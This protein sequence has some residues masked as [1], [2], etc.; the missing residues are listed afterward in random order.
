MSIRVFRAHSRRVLL[1]LVS[2]LFLSSAPLHFFLLAAGMFRYCL[3]VEFLIS[4]S[5][6]LRR[7][8]RLATKVVAPPIELS[9]LSSEAEQ[10][11]VEI[12][13]HVT[14]AAASS[15]ARF[16]PYPP[17]SVLFYT[18]AL[19]FLAPATA[20]SHRFCGTCQLFRDHTPKP[21]AHRGVDSGGAGFDLD[22]VCLAG[23]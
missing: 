22:W 15:T 2:L 23:H 10:N 21:R 4:T 14:A 11:D 13:S 9:S 6:G 3:L 5:A 19:G 16:G 12:I 20:A 17:Q 18:M 7:S 1:S 8:N